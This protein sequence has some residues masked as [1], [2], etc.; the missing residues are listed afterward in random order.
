MVIISLG[1]APC[2]DENC[3]NADA[4]R[5]PES[6]INGLVFTLEGVTLVR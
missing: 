4:N 1:T 6:F 5:P 2:R 3:N